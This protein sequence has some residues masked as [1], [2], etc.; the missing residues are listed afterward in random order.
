[1]LFQCKHHILSFSSDF[2]LGRAH[3]LLSCAAEQGGTFAG[4]LPK[5]PARRRAFPLLPV[6]WGLQ[7]LL[8]DH[9]QG[10]GF[11]AIR[12]LLVECHYGVWV[13]DFGLF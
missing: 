11:E 8:R 12:K 9:L 10:L 5:V 13:K 1:M 3:L 7:G 6:K 4:Y 2:L